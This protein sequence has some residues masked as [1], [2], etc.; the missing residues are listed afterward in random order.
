LP[1]NLWHALRESG[2]DVSALAVQPDLDPESSD[3]ALPATLSAALNPAQLERLLNIACQAIGDPAIGLWLGSRMRPAFFSMAGM[4]AM[5]CP[6]LGS[7]LRRIARY[8]GLMPG[9]SME[10]RE[11]GDEAWICIRHNGPEPA[12]PRP[13]IDLELSSLLAFG[14]C[15]TRRPLRPRWVLLRMGEPSWHQRYTEVF[16]CPVRFGQDVDAIVFGRHDLALRRASAEAASLP[17]QAPPQE[18]AQDDAIEDIRAALRQL[19]SDRS[20][21]LASVAHHL[22]ISERTLQRRLAEAGTGF[23]KLSD[24]VRGELARRYLAEPGHSLGD[25]AFR[26]GF[27]D[28]NSFFRSFRRWTGMTPGNFRRASRQSGVS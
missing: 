17:R 9:D 16:D 27:D 15:F 4:P 28:A 2:C 8:N 22:C 26:L 25:I 5:A 11:Q 24:D 13:R 10:V 23:R 21:S 18:L 20:L 14:R 12:Y 6:S 1:R 19:V 3:D 7:A